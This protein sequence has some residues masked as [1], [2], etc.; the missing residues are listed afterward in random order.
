[1]SPNNEISMQKRLKT[2]G[3]L[4]G[5]LAIWGVLGFRI[6]GALHP[7]VPQTSNQERSVL[8]SP[9]AINNV[10]SFSVQR[11]ERDPFLGTLTTIHKKNN[12]QKAISTVKKTEWPAIV[13]NGIISKQ[14]GSEKICIISINGIQSMMKIGQTLNGIR[15]LKAGPTE[16]QVSYKGIKKTISKT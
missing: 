11:M 6:I 16:I 3:L 7:K 12:P 10:D 5:V 15:L 9:K 1:M 13:Y 8:F 14:G 4:A 2:Y